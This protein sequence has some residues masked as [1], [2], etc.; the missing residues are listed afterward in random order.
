MRWTTKAF[1]QRTLERMPGG[2][3][4]YSLGQRYAGGLRH[5]RIDARMD[6]GLRMLKAL[7]KAGHNLNDRVAVEVGSGWVPIVSML[8]WLHGLKFCHTYDVTA[9]LNKSLV[10]ESA[11]QFV[12]LYE[13]P[14]ARRSAAPIN[15]H[16][17]RL[18]SLR[19][20]VMC[21]AD[22]DEILRLCQISYQAPV[23][24]AVTS[25]GAGSMA[26][27]FSNTV[28]EHVP[29]A[30][31]RR[32][33]KEA[34]R[35]LQSDGLMLHLIDLSDHFAHSDSS[36]SAVNFLIFSEEEFA[37]YNTCFCYQNRLRAPSYRKLIEESG[38]EVLHWDV[39]VSES[40]LHQLPSLKIHR[41]FAGF[42][43][44]ELCST[45]ISVVARRP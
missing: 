5:Y 33:F 28:L 37:I 41:D 20:L 30:E 14:V 39:G 42:S 34:F 29:L 27:F 19:A 24:T 3:T 1:I 22:A 16:E 43:P 13:D 2:R 32:L 21:K 18:E 17:D 25:H 26:L 31:I 8:F 44:E 11:W 38:F 12:T 10:V 36:I 45:S 23:D 35:L 6:E 9:L 4:I 40:A 7:T 15:L